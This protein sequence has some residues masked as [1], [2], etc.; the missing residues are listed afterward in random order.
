MTLGKQRTCKI[1][2]TVEC[3]L[4]Q[5]AMLLASGKVRAKDVKGKE[6]RGGCLFGV[7]LMSKVGSSNGGGDDTG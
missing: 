2:I 3:L 1:K 7:Y 4:W 5:E 6:T